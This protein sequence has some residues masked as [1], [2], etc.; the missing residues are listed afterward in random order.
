MYGKCAD[1]VLLTSLIKLNRK[2]RICSLRLAVSH[3]FVVGPFIKI[4]I[5]EIDSTPLL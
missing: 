3:P 2:Q 4:R 1:A 5:D